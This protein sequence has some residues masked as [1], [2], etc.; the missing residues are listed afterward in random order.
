MHRSAGSTTVQTAVLGGR[1]LYARFHDT[2]GWHISESLRT[3]IGSEAPTLDADRVA[4]LRSL[5][6]SDW[7]DGLASFLREVVVLEPDATYH[8]DD[9]NPV[10]DVEPHRHTWAESPP[11]TPATL[12]EH[13][14]AVLDQAAIRQQ[15]PL[16]LLSGGLDS[17]LLAV[18]MA[19]QGI[20]FDAVCVFDGHNADDVD[21]ATALA[22]ELDLSF[23]VHE[24]DYDAFLAGLPKSVAA[25]SD[26]RPDL[27][28]ASGLVDCLASIG[29]DTYRTV[30]G[31]EPADALLG[32]L[33]TQVT[34][35][36]N[37]ARDTS[38]LRHYAPR[39]REISR[40]WSRAATSSARAPAAHMLTSHWPRR[41]CRRHGRPFSMPTAPCIRPVSSAGRATR[42]SKPPQQTCCTVRN[43][44]KSP[45]APNAGF[46]H[47]S[48]DGG[49]VCAHR[50]IRGNHCHTRDEQGVHR[51]HRWQSLSSFR[52]RTSSR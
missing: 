23:T 10:C 46:R 44:A 5:P 51:T 11:L 42:F 29:P 32:G 20:V 47:S 43:C 13:I 45:S 39:S 9:G 28:L 7:P 17:A 19:E 27:F 49:D 26:P 50:P 12:L 16:L 18:V 34:A 30:I 37:A 8:F 33:R 35:P 14:T 31:G 6:L 22:T 48:V 36:H 2:D 40:F 15:P 41:R 38:E 25:F 4:R 1:P 3:V 52:S 21:Y 24:F